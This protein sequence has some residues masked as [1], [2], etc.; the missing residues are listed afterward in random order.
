VKGR[1]AGRKEGT[2]E[3][4]KGRKEGTGG[5]KERRNGEGKQEWQAARTAG[6]VEGRPEGRTVVPPSLNI[7]SVIN[8]LPQ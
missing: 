8:P 5:R 3:G 4:K 2:G 7:P 1:K 6:T